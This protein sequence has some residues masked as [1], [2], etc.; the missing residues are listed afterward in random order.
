MASFLQ[1]TTI[2]AANSTVTGMKN[3]M[4]LICRMSVTN[5][6]GLGGSFFKGQDQYPRADH[7]NTRPFAHRWTFMEEQKGKDGHE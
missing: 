6:I 1:P 4:A 3:F 5:S 2:S 7:E